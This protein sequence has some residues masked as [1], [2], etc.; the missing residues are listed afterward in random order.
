MCNFN[1]THAAIFHK[2]KI[3]KNIE[4]FLCHRK[5]IKHV[6]SPIINYSVEILTQKKSSYTN[7]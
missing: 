6:Q 3:L 4:T 2:Y 7:L 5:S 1:S